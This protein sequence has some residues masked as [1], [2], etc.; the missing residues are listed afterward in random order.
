MSSAALLACPSHMGR[1]R[2][3]DQST[4]PWLEKPQALA[5]ISRPV[6]REDS[7]A[8]TGAGSPQYGVCPQAEDNQGVGAK[9]ANILVS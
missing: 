5:A 7:A 3:G 8:R 1:A 2:S 4:P 6:Y 9:D